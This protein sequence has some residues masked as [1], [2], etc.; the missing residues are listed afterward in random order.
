M[1]PTERHRRL[2][3]APNVELD[4]VEAGTPG[5][6]VVVLLH[7]FPETSYSWRNQ[8][9]PLADAGYHVIAPDQRGYA[10]SSSPSNVEA[11][12]AVHLTADVVAILDEANSEQAIIVGHDWGAIVAW[13]MGLLHPDRCRAVVAASVPFNEWPAPPTE[14]FKRLH[15][16]RFFYILY[17]QEPGVAEAELDADP[18]R[19]LQSIYWVAAAESG[20]GPLSSGL[21]FRETTLIAAFEHQLGRRPSEPPPWMTTTDF[22]TYVEQ[23]RQ[24]G[25]RGPI[26]WYRNF[27]TNYAATKQLD[28]SVLSMP[29]AFVGGALDPVIVGAPHVVTKQADR[30]PNYLGGHLIEGAGHWVQQEAPDE[31]NRW[32]LATLQQV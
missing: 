19:F 14:V 13:H 29:T 9:A 5:D 1:P 16:E 25:F 26:D 8:M 17:F 6:P 24:S 10:H 32:L 15:G 4:L 11:F 31:F 2:T 27:D 21:P 3:V 20:G 23:F 22:N 7:G 18:E 28:P 30:L 12:A